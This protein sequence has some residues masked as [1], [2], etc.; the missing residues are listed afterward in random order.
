MTHLSAYGRD[1][2]KVCTGLILVSCQL[3]S[4][5]SASSVVGLAIT[6]KL[7]L[8]QNSFKELYWES[9]IASEQS[10]CIWLMC[11]SFRLIECKMPSNPGKDLRGTG[12]LHAFSGY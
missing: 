5:T 11:V 2:S 4:N 9:F 7:K 12:V 8:S 10:A 1:L 6:L 3:H